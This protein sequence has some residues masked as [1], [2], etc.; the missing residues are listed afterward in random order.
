MNF[1]H[2]RFTVRGVLMEYLRRPEAAIEAYREALRARPD[3]L[4]AVR[5]IAWL[6]A[7]SQRWDQAAEWLEKAAA[8]EPEHADTWFNLG[9]A[10][11]R[12]GD[13]PAALEAFRRATALNPRHD[14]AWYGQ[15]MIH[16]HLGDHLAAAEALKQAAEL[17]PMNGPAWYALGMA[18]H[19]A[20]NPD[21]VRRVVEHCATH[22]PQAAR[23]LIQEAERADLRGLLAR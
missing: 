20:N 2:W 13:R 4:K 5:S 3:D 21:A 10:R 1:D 22:D 6:H 17:Q 14:R 7:Q 9:Y 15:G 23:R 12:H 11:E 8:L 16:A 18:Y 19:H